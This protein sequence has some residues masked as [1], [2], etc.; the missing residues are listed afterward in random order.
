MEYAKKLKIKLNKTI[1]EMVSNSSL[2]VKNSKSDFT[3]KRVLT[4]LEIV[5]IILSMGGNSLNKNC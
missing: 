4:F 3:R 1:S 2:F 5:K